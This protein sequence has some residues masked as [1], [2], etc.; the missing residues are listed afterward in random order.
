MKKVVIISSSFRENGNSYMLCKE[1]KRGAEKAGNEVELIT[2]KENLKYCTGCEKCEKTGKCFHKD[3]VNKILK[4]I[5]NS[6]VLVFASPIY[7]YNISGQLK[8]FIDRTLPVYHLIH[9]KDFYFLGTC[10]DRREEAFDNAMSSIEGF[11]DSLKNVEL[12]GYVYGINVFEKGEM[13]DNSPA[14]KK[15]YDLGF[16]IKDVE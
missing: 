12:K 14:M 13:K 8:T 6:D 5:V 16:S 2:L 11:L 15:A 9:D 4:K 10:A 1:F 7:F 3:G